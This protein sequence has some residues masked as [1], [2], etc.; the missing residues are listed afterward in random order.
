MNAVTR[1]SPV[2]VTAPAAVLSL[3]ACGPADGGRPDNNTDTKSTPPAALRLV[4]PYPGA[5]VKAAGYGETK[6]AAPTTKPEGRAKN[7]RVVISAT[8]S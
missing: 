4:L 8:R 6:P 3:S 5:D 2:L 7:R 1:L